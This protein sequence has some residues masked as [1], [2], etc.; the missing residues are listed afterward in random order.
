MNEFYFLFPI[1]LG[2]RE[3]KR[4]LKDKT[5]RESELFASRLLIVTLVTNMIRRICE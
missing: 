4:V 5:G 2:D 3:R 1:L